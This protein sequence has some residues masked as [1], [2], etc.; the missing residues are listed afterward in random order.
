M[1]LTNSLT[2][3]VVN[4]ADDKADRFGSDWVREDPVE[5]KAPATP[6]PPATKPLPPKPAAAAPTK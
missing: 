2:G 4:V 6:A 3:M 1:R 5:A